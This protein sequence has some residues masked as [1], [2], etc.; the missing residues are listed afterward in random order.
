MTWWSPGRREY[1]PPASF[2][3]LHS[4]PPFAPLRYAKGGGMGVGVGGPN[5][6][7]SPLDR[8]GGGVGSVLDDVDFYGA[9]GFVEG[10]VEGGGDLF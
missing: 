7:N 6:F 8:Q 1:E 2:A 9:G 5:P 4:R 3:A 10:G